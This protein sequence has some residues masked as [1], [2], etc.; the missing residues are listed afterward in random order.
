MTRTCWPL[1][2]MEADGGRSLTVLHENTPTDVKQVAIEL[3]MAAAT[4]VGCV[5]AGV[6]FGFVLGRIGRAG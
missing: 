6:G 5:C 4:V 3:W 2:L 1:A